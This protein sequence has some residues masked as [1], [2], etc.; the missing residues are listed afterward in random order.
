M[1]AE[2]VNDPSDQWSFGA[3]DTEVDL[4]VECIPD[5]CFEVI[6]GE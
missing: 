2:V 5:Q 6:G 1:L 3:G 4:V